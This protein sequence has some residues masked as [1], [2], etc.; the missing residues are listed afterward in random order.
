MDKQSI[1]KDLNPQQKQAVQHGNGPLLVLAGAGSGKTRVLTHRFAYLCSIKKF[2]PTSI[3]C[4]TFTNKA[5]REMKARTEKL[6][7][8]KLKD[9]WIGTFH[10]LSNR[11]LRKEIEPLGFKR[12]FVIYDENDSCS[13]I[14][15]I[16]KDF[17]IHEALYKGIVSKISSLKAAL[18]GPEKFLTIT[19]AEDRYGFDE[20]FARVYVRYKEELQKNN[21]LDFDDLIMCTVRLFEEYPDIMK[22]YNKMFP[23]IMIDEFQDTNGAQ[24]R[25]ANLLAGTK[26]NI[27]VVGDD[28]QS[29]YRFRGAEVKNILQFEKDFK[30]TKVIRLE[31]NYRST[32]NILEAAS[33]MI[34]QNAL[35]K[36]KKLWSDRDKGEKIFYC[37]TNNEIEEARYIS[38]SIK[39]LYLKGKHSYGDF[40]VLYRVNFQ[41]K[42]L[43]EVLREE[44]ISYRVIGG[45]SFFQRKE[46]KD[47]IAYLKVI[48][49]PGDSVSLKRII[50]CPPRGIG[51]ASI[52]RI[53]NESR[54]KGKTMFD[55]MKGLSN[56]SAS[57]T[58]LSKKIKGF[59][60]TIEELT[61][62]KNSNADK[63]LRHVL[64]KT[65]YPEWAGE[66]RGVN[67]MEFVT[68][69][70]G[71]DLQ[72]V[73][74]TSS[75]HSCVD[76]S[77][78]GDFVS[79]MTLHSAKGLEFPVVF[80]VGVED[81]LLPHFHALK[82]EAELQEERRLFYVGMTR[83]RDL[84]VLSNAKKRKLYASLQKQK[85]SR[86]LHEIPNQ[87]YHYI[88]KKPKKEA[89]VATI[90]IPESMQH[91][92]P[93]FTGVRV[94]HPKWG[95]G[96]VRDCYGD[97]DDPK[98]M[99]NF[100]SVGVK[101]LSV[102]LA[103]LE[104]L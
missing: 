14:R 4:M 8:R 43:E 91:T 38:R 5:A 7:G 62:L 10:S 88:E 85:S 40:S 98:V 58:A 23:Y 3:L 63:L 70:K 33:G 50:N 74:D 99:V 36:P 27:F 47:M 26:K 94:K 44:G 35:R 17:N 54:K 19:S 6:M 46:I 25:L 81:G 11:I 68:F 78:D 53:E 96:V 16:L 65:G 1:F 75:L 42:I 80:I 95:V 89:V 61:R 13:L 60:T 41:S 66:D 72:T 12:N 77:H 102:K 64:T 28:D 69:A 93:F 15:T 97:C 103:S 90:D 32:K 104:K 82:K 30:K 51:A 34:L 48:A 49:N 67:L 86:F 56:G 79:L 57:S 59:V 29:I 71:K 76:D 39:E 31:Q 83:A 100:S 101:K 92:S 52:A 2:P 37:V 24:Y 73:I 45:I 55:T 18:I 22:K 20:K 21:A 87:C 84:L 9:S